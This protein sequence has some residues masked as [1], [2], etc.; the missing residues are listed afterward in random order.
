MTYPTNAKTWQFTV[1]QT[2]AASG[3]IPNDNKAVLLAIKN[4]LLAFGSNPWT[5]GYSCSSTVAGSVGDGVD[6]WATIA[7][8]VGNVAASAHSWIVLKQTGLAASGQLLIAC[9]SAN[10]NFQQ[11]TLK[12]SASAGFTGG[13]TTAN[14]T[15]TDSLSILTAANWINNA[16]D[17]QQ[18]WHAEQ[19]SDGQCTRVMTA[20]S[21]AVTGSWFFEKLANATTGTP[22]ADNSG[23]MSVSGVAA[24][25]LT[26]V[27]K[28]NS[29]L[30]ATAASYESVQTALSIASEVDGLW[31]MMPVACYG[32][33]AGARGRLGTFQDL[34]IGSSGAA[35]G[36][37]YTDGT[38]FWAHIGNIIVPWP[39]LTVNLT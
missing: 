8:I 30:S 32:T 26:G 12:W 35:S 39:S 9:D 19:S 11:L 16:A 2:V 25:T 27:T 20:A 28:Q 5:V 15:A 38:Y 17:V 37:V 4:A 3:S 13:T 1:N 29:I 24:P 23:C 22:G 18:R 31:P 10:V 14:P 7:N 21:G 6:R 33:T 36:D 34:W